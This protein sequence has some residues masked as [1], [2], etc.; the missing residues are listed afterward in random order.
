MSLLSFHKSLW[1]SEAS[2]LF[3]IPKQTTAWAPI[4]LWHEYVKTPRSAPYVIY[5]IYFNIE[6]PNTFSELADA[7][8]VLLKKLVKFNPVSSFVVTALIAASIL[9]SS[10]LSPLVKDLLDRIF[11]GRLN[12][13]VFSQGALL[14]Y[15]FSNE[16][17]Y[18]VGSFDPAYIKLF[19]IALIFA[20]ANVLLF[21]L[22]VKAFYIDRMEAT[23]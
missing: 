13:M 8:A 23:K 18:A 6:R 15:L 22:K 9:S 10:A 5:S 2:D 11:S 19:F 14:V 20:L 17:Y 4:L 21:F 3:S 16:S 7:F 1:E 12:I